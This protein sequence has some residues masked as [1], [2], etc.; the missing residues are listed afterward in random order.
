MRITQETPPRRAT[1]KSQGAA[2]PAPPQPW[3]M[4]M[5]RFVT[6]AFRSTPRSRGRAEGFFKVRWLTRRLRGGRS[7][8]CRELLSRRFRSRGIWACAVSSP[9]P[10]ARRR[11]LEGAPRAVGRSGTRSSQRI[12]LLARARDVRLKLRVGG[13][14]R[15]YGGRCEPSCIHVGYVVHAAHD[16][17]L[18][19]GAAAR[20]DGRG[21][22][23]RD[24]GQ[25]ER[26]HPADGRMTRRV[27]AA[28]RELL[29]GRDA[30][31]AALHYEGTL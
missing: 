25:H 13:E 7:R 6:R 26:V 19:V 22:L 27:G 28:R 17:A 30:R 12:E 21:V 18:A 10:F 4:G 3:H 5:R 24:V 20:E 15:E 1:P 23:R 14:R 8:N 2:Y 31:R 29:R 16:A 9:G 11:V